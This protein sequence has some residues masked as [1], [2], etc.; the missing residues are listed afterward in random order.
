MAGSCAA[1]AV[2]DLMDR[3][4]AARAW[5]AANKERV[6]AYRRAYYAAN[7]VRAKEMFDAFHRANPEKRVEYQRA[8]V[9]R[10]A[11]KVKAVKRAP[12]VRAQTNAR[13][14]HRYSTDPA[15]RLAKV[16]RSNFRRV[17]VT[18]V[19][20]QV[21]VLTL[22]G[23]DMAALKGH[24]EAQFVDGMSWDNYGI[25]DGQPIWEIDHKLPVSAFDILD[26]EQQRACWHWSNLQPMWAS[27]NRRK[28]GASR[29]VVSS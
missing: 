23:C 24:L 14:A 26:V 9:Y 11:D 25:V 10:H 12:S 19:R 18:G 21:S 2:H 22:V 29:M 15:Y 6:K 7:K 28:G 8:Y 3:L 1:E 16:L 4:E 17:M 5:K 20:K 13:A 27:E